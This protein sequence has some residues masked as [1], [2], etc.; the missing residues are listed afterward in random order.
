MIMYKRALRIC[1][2]IVFFLFFQITKDNFPH[3]PLSSTVFNE[4]KKW[5]LHTSF[6]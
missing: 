2:N 6:K 1:K 5:I 4:R 3:G